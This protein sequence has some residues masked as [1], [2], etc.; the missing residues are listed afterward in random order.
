MG[1]TAVP[2]MKLLATIRKVCCHGEKEVKNEYDKCL[3]FRRKPEKVQ[4]DGQFV[5]H[6]KHGGGRAGLQPQQG[7]CARI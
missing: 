7:S 5:G 6:H 1:V 2:N 4:P 3:N